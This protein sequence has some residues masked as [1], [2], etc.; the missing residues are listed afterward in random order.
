MELAE[1]R[2]ALVNDLRPMQ[3]RMAARHP[4]FVALTF[5]RLVERAPSDAAQLPLAGDEECDEF[6]AAISMEM[7]DAAAGAIGPIW[8]AIL[9]Q[10]LL[11]ALIRAFLR[12]L[13]ASEQNRR[14]VIELRASLPTESSHIPVV[15]PDDEPDFAAGS[16][17]VSFDRP[18]PT[19]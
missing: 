3:Q 9:L 6:A 2:D 18:Q 17:P 12:W 7:A 13:G 14:A 19:S 10:V 8:W 11:P 5:R 4:E 16:E 15:G 1:L